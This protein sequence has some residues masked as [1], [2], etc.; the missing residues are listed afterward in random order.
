M[1]CSIDGDKNLYLFHLTIV[2]SGLKWTEREG[3]MYIYFRG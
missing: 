2:F 1:L 3:D